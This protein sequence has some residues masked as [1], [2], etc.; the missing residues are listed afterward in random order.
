MRF[1]SLILFLSCLSFISYGKESSD[2]VKYFYHSKWKSQSHREI[3]LNGNGDHFLVTSSHVS[4]PPVFQLYQWQQAPSTSR[5]NFEKINFSDLKN[6]AKDN[7]SNKPYTY[8]IVASEK[9][10]KT[11]DLQKYGELKKLS[12]EEVFGY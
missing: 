10:I 8:C 11:E 1:V 12:L 9:K 2:T 3:K 5:I 4:K 6:F 7:L